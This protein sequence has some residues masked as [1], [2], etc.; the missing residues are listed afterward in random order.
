MP[1]HFLEYRVFNLSSII[2]FLVI[3]LLDLDLAQVL[4]SSVY[5]N[6]QVVVKVPEPTQF[7]AIK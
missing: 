1:S 6:N 5:A 7:H 4:N 2:L 3:E